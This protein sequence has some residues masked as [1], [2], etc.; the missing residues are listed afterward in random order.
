[1][2]S[3]DQL[4]LSIWFI[5]TLG[6]LGLIVGSFLNV[7]IVRVPVGASV[8]RPRS[9]CSE[10]NSAIAS[11]DNIPIISWLILRGRC[12]NCSN[13]ISKSYPIVEGIT[14]LVW[15]AFGWWGLLTSVPSA[16]VNPLLPLV[17]ALSS[18]LI[19]LFVI[20]IQWHRLPNLIVYSLYPISLIGFSVAL[21]IESGS[22]D[23][24]HLVISSCT[25]ALLWLGVIG[26]LWLVSRGRAMGLGD[27]K[28]AP[29]LGAVLGW[30]SVSS[31]AIGLMAAFLVGA[32]MGLSL[33]VARQAQ[34]RNK[35]AFGPF[36][37]IGYAIGLVAGPPLWDWYAGLVK[38]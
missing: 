23:F 1:V 25:G 32:V 28:L 22:A 24:T 3:G 2:S 34:M 19:A 37:I 38:L 8:I 20:D 26:A 4:I 9:R 29:V 14:A 5:A 17:L 6:V 36:L 10:C 15:M 21:I 12:R 31:A 11:R 13:P 35:I 7:V 33:I 27:V 30:Q 16:W 18:A